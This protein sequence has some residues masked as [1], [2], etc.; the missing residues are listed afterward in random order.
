MVNNIESSGTRILLIR[1]GETDWNRI[2]RFQGRSDLP[3]N[4]K[5]K[6]QAHA[7]ALALKDESLTAIYSSPLIR[8][9]ETARLIKVF[10]PSIPLFEEEGLV[11]MNLGEFEGMEAQHWAAE[12][13]DFLRTWQ[14]TPASVT[15]PG[16]E[17]LQEV[18]TRAIGTLERI[19]KLYPTES[20]LLLCSHNFVNLTMLCYALRVPLDRFREVRQETAA[21]N[22]LYM[23]GQRLWAKVV[24]ERS[25]LKRPIGSEAK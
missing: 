12:Y 14:E 9:L 19:T 25:Y 6:D 18:Q 3:L 21:L 10:H 8:T 15:M 4:Q 13:P 7:L 23:Q 17:S 2:R 11:E 22:V 1:H 24:N 20:T 5:G 16:G